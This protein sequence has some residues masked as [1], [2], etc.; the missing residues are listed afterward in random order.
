MPAGAV[1]GAPVLA[2]HSKTDVEPAPD[3]ALGITRNDPMA[4]RALK[5]RM[6]EA[7][8]SVVGDGSEGR[9][10]RE[11]HVSSLTE[12][13]AALNRVPAHLE[14]GYLEL[15]AEEL[16]AARSAI[17]ALVGITTTEDVLGAIFSRFCIGK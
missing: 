10:I 5:E 7:A 14:R 3:G 8:L 13:R 2:V 15:A 17:G 6:A 11:R 9:L 12:A 4:I 16:R 1:D